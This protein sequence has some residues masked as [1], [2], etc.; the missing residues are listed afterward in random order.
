MKIV[1]F[2]GSNSE[3][4][5]NFQLVTFAAS[6]FDT[7]EIKLLKTADFE[8]HLYSPERELETGIP[9]LILDFAQ[10]ISSADLVLLSLAEHNGSYSAAFKNLYD[11]ISRIPNRKVFDNKPLILLSTS[12]GARGG[13]SVLQ[14]AAER[15]P[16]DG[17]E[18]IGTF[19]LPSFGQNFDR[20][21]Q[22]IVDAKLKMELR[23]IVENAKAIVKI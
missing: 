22:E 10:E 23:S 17:A 14:S 18:L 7:A 13:Q 1:A 12:P 21:K 4:S 16:R 2:A 20:D 19:S 6:L 15:F 5:I 3:K 8:T 9:Q 11:W